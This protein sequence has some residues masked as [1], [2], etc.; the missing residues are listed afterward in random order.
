[1][2]ELLALIGAAQGI[3]YWLGIIAIVAGLIVMVRGQLAA[4]IVL[5][6]VGLLLAFG[7]FAVRTG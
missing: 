3:L 7:G 6:I 1:M 5:I 4:G 2:I